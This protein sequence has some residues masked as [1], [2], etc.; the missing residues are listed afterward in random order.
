MLWERGF[1]AV[2]QKPDSRSLILS[3]ARH[4]FAARGFHQ[5][6]MSELAA[7]AQ[8]SVG[9]IYRSFKNKNDIIVAIV[10]DDMVELLGELEEVLRRVRA[11]EMSVR[12]AFEK[13]V[14]DN[15]SEHEGGL[16][17]EI[18]AEA[19]RNPVVG[20]RISALLKPCCA[21]LRALACETNKSLSDHDLDAA[22]ELLLACL[23]GLGHRPL[24]RH[25]RDFMATVPE[26]ARMMERALKG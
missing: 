22:E 1:D 4:L 15:L 9:Q 2:K 23:F 11:A 14:S 21:T 7:E 18:L 5:T 8:V 26:I 20:D 6:A 24:S 3:A 10:G 12:E 13:L 25:K 17:F 19:H 16:G